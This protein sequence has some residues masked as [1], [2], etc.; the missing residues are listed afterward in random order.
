MEKQI[1]SIDYMVHCFIASIN[2]KLITR[3]FAFPYPKSC[4]VYIIIFKISIARLH[5]YIYNKLDAPATLSN[6]IFLFVIADW[7][8]PFLFRNN[9]VCI[10]WTSCNKIRNVLI[11]SYILYVLVKA[12]M[13][14][15]YGTSKYSTRGGVEKL[16]KRLSARRSRVLRDPTPSAI[17]PS[18]AL[19]K[20][21][22]YSSLN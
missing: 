1:L 14:V 16:I 19:A 10:L 22:V 5:V 2:A 21:V 9:L 8:S 4:H 13:L 6:N 7:N 18:T 3:G 17:F 12:L 11:Y 15:L 20:P